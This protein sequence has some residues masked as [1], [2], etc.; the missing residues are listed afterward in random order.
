LKAFTFSRNPSQF[1]LEK[2]TFE[3]FQWAFVML[4]SRAARLASKQTGEELA[5]VPYADLMNHNPY[6]K[7]HDMIIST[8]TSINALLF[9]QA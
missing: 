6:S 1:P 4:F 5:L 3:L 8:M 9:N 2:Y 7:L